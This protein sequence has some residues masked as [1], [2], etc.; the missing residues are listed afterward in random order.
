MRVLVGLF[1]IHVHHAVTQ[2]KLASQLCLLL[3]VQAVTSALQ[4]AGRSLSDTGGLLLDLVVDETAERC[5]AVVRQLKGIT[6]TYRMTSKGPPTR[7][8]HYV[9]GGG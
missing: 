4:G 6:A 8:S 3:A 1:S 9:T 7:H 2:P 5:V